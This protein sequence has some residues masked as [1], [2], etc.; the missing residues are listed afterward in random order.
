MTEFHITTQGV[1]LIMLRGNQRG[2]NTK[3]RITVCSYPEAFAYGNVVRHG[4]WKWRRRKAKLEATT[5]LQ[6]IL[7]RRMSRAHV[8]NVISISPG[9]SLVLL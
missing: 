4:T 9:H 3:D 7:T 6:F 1:G 2:P 5:N 8:Q